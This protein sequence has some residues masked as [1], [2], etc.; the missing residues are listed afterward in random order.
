MLLRKQLLVEV[1]CGV[2]LN[3]LV[4]IGRKQWKNR[5]ARIEEI[6]AESFFHVFAG[7]LSLDRTSRLIEHFQGDVL[8]S[9]RLLVSL[10]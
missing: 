2:I 3:G 5:K 8:F 7:A 10:G 1:F 4:I 6:R 9:F